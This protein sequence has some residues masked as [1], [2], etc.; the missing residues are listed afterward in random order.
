MKIGGFANPAALTGARL[1]RI[2]VH[3]SRG[4]G[5]RLGFKHGL[6]G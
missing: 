3:A 5:S 4:I 2:V 6:A 1:M